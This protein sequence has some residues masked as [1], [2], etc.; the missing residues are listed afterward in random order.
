MQ[1]L[2]TAL[3][4]RLCPPCSDGAL[5]LWARCNSVLGFLCALFGGH[6]KARMSQTSPP[7]LD[8]ALLFMRARIM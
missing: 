5:L 1:S 7:C 4:L 8:G 6:L 3:S 2:L